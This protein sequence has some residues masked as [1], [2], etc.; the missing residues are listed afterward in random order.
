MDAHADGPVAFCVQFQQDTNDHI[1]PPLAST[2]LLKRFLRF[3]FV[4]YDPVYRHP[5]ILSAFSFIASSPALLHIPYLSTSNSPLA[6]LISYMFIRY[7]T[8]LCKLSPPL[9]H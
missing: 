7:K 1:L 9:S 6:P 8:R 2:C 3:K 4:A 5:T